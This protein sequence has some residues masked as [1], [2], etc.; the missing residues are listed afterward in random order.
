[1]KHL[2]E[3][4]DVKASG[5]GM[6]MMAAGPAA[7]VVDDKNDLQASSAIGSLSAIRA[8]VASMLVRA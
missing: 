2:E 8:R 5:G 6:M 7:A 1:M 4:W 3:K